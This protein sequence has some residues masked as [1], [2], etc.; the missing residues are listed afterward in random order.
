MESHS[1]YAN[2]WVASLDRGP[3]EFHFYF[4]EIKALS[5]ALKVSFSH[6]GWLANG[7]AVLWSN[8]GWIG[9]FLCLVIC[10]SVLV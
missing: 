5:S 2:H 4:N 10:T 6:V 8:N 3:W 1:S 9:F 7:M